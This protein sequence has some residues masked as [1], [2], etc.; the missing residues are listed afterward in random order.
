MLNVTY[1]GLRKHV[2]TIDG[3]ATSCFQPGSRRL[4]LRGPRKRWRSDHAT[5]EF[6]SGLEPPKGFVI[7]TTFTGFLDQP[8]NA[9]ILLAEFPPVAFNQF[10]NGFTADAMAKHGMRLLSN[11]T[12]DGVPYEQITVRAEQRVG[13]QIFD[14]WLMTINGP[15][16]VGM[17][18]VSIA[19]PAPP[20][21][22]D[23][24]IRAALAS[25]RINATASVDPR[26]PPCRSRSSRQRASNTASPWP[27]GDLLLKET[28]PPPEGQLDDV[29]FIV[30]LA[31]E[32][33]HCAL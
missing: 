23:A 13:N 4:A 6:A 21:L 18:T 28:P 5:R 24:V 16:V 32:D 31:G 10:R 12:I 25:V 2:A 22:S 3:D 14:K 11:E 19:K 30:T 1:R 17:V 26:S 8:D 29:G 15:D 33:S 27:A 9:S 20:R 7:A